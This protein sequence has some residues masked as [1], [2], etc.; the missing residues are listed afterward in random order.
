MTLS[1]SLICNEMQAVFQ[2]DTT[3][4]HK[5]HHV[6]LDRYTC[7]T[8]LWSHVV[9]VICILQRITNIPFR[10]KSVSTFVLKRFWQQSKSH[11]IFTS[12]RW[13]LQDNDGITWNIISSQNVRSLYQSHTCLNMSPVQVTMRHLIT[14]EQGL[15]LTS[16]LHLAFHPNWVKFQET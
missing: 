6:V 4:S 11:F 16:L 2:R 5:H 10:T 13:K 8:R 12:L 7:L 14:Y 15:Y 1:K 9:S 3:L